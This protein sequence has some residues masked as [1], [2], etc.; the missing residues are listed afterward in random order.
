MASFVDGQG[1]A[2]D[3]SRAE[4]V[5]PATWK[6]LRKTIAIYLYE[7]NGWTYEEIGRLFGISNQHA[8]RIIGRTIVP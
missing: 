7:K 8:C 1:E 5:A 6:E 4:T 2:I 3:L